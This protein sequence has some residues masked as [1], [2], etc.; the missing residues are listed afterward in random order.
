MWEYR[1]LLGYFSVEHLGYFQFGLL[2]LVEFFCGH[3]FSP[4]CEIVGLQ[5]IPFYIPT[6][7]YKT[8]DYSTSL[9]LFGVLVTG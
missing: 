5:D 7:T 9:T 6:A 4:R 2:L 8:C 3:L 1:L